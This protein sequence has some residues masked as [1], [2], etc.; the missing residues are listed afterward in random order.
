M[1]LYRHLCW[2]AIKQSFNQHL[3]GESMAPHILAY[4]AP[5]VLSWNHFPH[6]LQVILNLL[7]A[8]TAHGIIAVQ[9]TSSCIM[10]TFCIKSTSVRQPSDTTRDGK[11]QPGTDN[12]QLGTDNIQLGTDKIQLGT[13]NIQLGTD[14]IQLGTD[15]I[16]LRTDK[17]LLWTDKIQLGRTRYS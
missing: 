16:Q 15:K 14:K 11:I 9:M 10:S 8:H 6:F 1:A 12:I 4:G 3:A 13:D 2:C 7:C 17:I 5:K